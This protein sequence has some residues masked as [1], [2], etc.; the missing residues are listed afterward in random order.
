MQKLGQKGDSILKMEY[1]FRSDG[2]G[3]SGLYELFLYP[4]RWGLVNHYLGFRQVVIPCQSHN[5]TKATGTCIVSEVLKA[6]AYL[7]YLTDIPI[8]AT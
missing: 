5:F 3:E 8:F 4:D 6:C 2:M 1:R 7:R